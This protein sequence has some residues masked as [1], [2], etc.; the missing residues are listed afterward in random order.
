MP[1]TPDAG[2]DPV[3]VAEVLAAL[4]P[5]LTP[6]GHPAASRRHVVVDC[7]LGRAGH[8]R[9][10]LSELSGADLFIGL[11]IDPANL[12]FAESRLRGEARCE[13]RLFH[14]NFAQIAEVLAEVGVGPDAGGGQ[15]GVSAVLADLGVSTNQLL[16]VRY[17]LTFAED[18]PLDMRLDP[19]QGVSAWEIVNRWSERELAD[20]LYRNADERLSRRIARR[21]AEERRHGPINSTRRLAELVRSVAGRGAHPGGIDPATRT[22]QALRMEANRE[23]DNLRKLLETAPD[24]LAVGGRLAVISFHSGEDRQVKRVFRE[25]ESAA[26]AAAGGSGAVGTAARSFSVVTR[27]P[28][29]PSDA[30]LS[31]NPRARSAKLRVLQRT[32]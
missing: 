26:G 14:A 3:L 2:H 31:V 12:A 5:A 20:V 29:T 27:K 4:R 1:Q 15:G 7:T 22:F 18:A 10:L 21:I 19:S 6:A 24:V 16:D 23:V 8:A 25:R 32:A 9:A 30:E 13:V 11:D 17:G 28:I